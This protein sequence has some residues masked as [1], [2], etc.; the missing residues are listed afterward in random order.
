MG[1]KNPYITTIGFKRDDSDHVYVAELL[2]SMSWGEAQYIVKAVMLYRDMQEN[3]EAVPMGGAY[4][5][6]RIR[7]VA[8]QV[9]EERERITLQPSIEHSEENIQKNSPPKGMY[10]LK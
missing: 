7:R 3:G 6:A 8:L 1:K 5:Y 2:N 9:I 4:D 10:F